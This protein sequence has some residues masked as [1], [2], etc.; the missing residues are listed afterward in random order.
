[1]KIIVTMGPS[2]RLTKK[3]LFNLASHRYI[4][5]V[6][7]LFLVLLLV[8]APHPGMKDAEGWIRFS[9]YFPAIASG[10]V[11]FFTL[12]FAQLF[13]SPIIFK[14][15]IAH[16]APSLFISA[17]V[18]LY[19]GIVVADFFGVLMP[20]GYGWIMAIISMNYAM[21]EAIFFLVRQFVVDRIL[22]KHDC[23]DKSAPE[24]NIDNFPSESYIIHVNGRRVNVK[25]IVR[26]KSNG[27]YVEI[28]F[29]EGKVFEHSTLKNTVSLIPDGIG[30]QIHRGQWVAYSSIKE[31]RHNRRHLSILLNDGSILPVARHRQSELKRLF[32]RL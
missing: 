15:S 11:V 28:Y 9:V 14:K 24:T 27:N 5:T 2:I 19:V 4:I 1:M 16:T 10:Y 12:I 18:S 29:T 20:P 7:A 6:S 21:G 30:V 25:D 26:I 8:I 22:E 17:C 23:A 3:E 13:I 32:S 31:L